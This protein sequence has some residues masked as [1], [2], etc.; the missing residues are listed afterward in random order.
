[1]AAAVAHVGLRSTSAPY[2]SR[3][4][5]VSKG[6]PQAD[7]HVIRQA[8]QTP[9]TRRMRSQT[10][11]REASFSAITAQ[12]SQSFSLASSTSSGYSKSRPSLLHEARQPL[13]TQSGLT[14]CS[15][16]APM[17]CHQSWRY[18]VHFRQP[19]PGVLPSSPAEIEL[20]GRTAS[21]MH[22]HTAASAHDISTTMLRI[23]YVLIVV[24]GFVLA[25]S[26]VAA[27]PADKCVVNGTVTYQQGPC[28]SDEVRKPPT[29]QELNAA[30]KRRRAAAVAASP[31]KV[32]AVTPNVSSGF[33]CDG[34]KYCS[35]MKSCAEAKYFLANCPGVKIDGDRNG[36][37]CE[38][39]WC[40]R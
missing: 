11:S 2:P 29:I 33:S 20:Q 36:I 40:V 21:N 28:R 24:A 18:A 22:S 9:T 17:A 38:Q 8:P 4:I 26:G 13:R 23:S 35:Q 7:P 19:G 10:A 14:P 5:L 30:E 39:Q 34:R 16:R 3:T 31:D 32:A 6:R 15:S 25:A 1:M 27:A 12:R 37:P